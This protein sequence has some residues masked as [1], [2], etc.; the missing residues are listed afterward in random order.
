MCSF[1]VDILEAGVAHH[2]QEIALGEV[3]QR[4]AEDVGRGGGELRR[5]PAA[6]ELGQG[7]PGP[8]GLAVEMAAERG[9]DDGI[10]AED[11]LAEGDAAARPEDAVEV[12][13]HRRLVGEIGQHRAH[14]HAVAAGIGDGIRLLGRALDD[15][16]A[17]GHAEIAGA[18]G[19][20]PQAVGGGIGADDVQRW[21]DAGQGLEGQEPVAGPHV[22][23]GE[24]LLQRGPR[25][26]AIADR[27]DGGPL[28]LAILPITAVALADQPIAPGVGHA[29]FQ[30]AARAPVLIP[31]EA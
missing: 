15:G 7:A 31:P 26:D 27:V 17:P 14:H 23:D 13:D 3:G 20:Q 8:G 28:H 30:R 29:S 19:D 24:P 10:V 5:Q 16:A 11:G 4:I 6:L 18:L 25:E 9:A 12:A 2:Q 22:D 1:E 21:P